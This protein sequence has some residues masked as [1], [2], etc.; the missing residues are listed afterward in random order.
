V[1]PAGGLS[2]FADLAAACDCLAPPQVLQARIPAIE[3]AFAAF[4]RCFAHLKDQEK[5]LQRPKPVLFLERSSIHA[6]FIPM[7]TCAT[8]TSAQERPTQE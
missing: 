7:T 6:H 5:A 2:R 1:A 8:S 4:E 3:T